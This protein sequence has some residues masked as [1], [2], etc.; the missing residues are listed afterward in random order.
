MVMFPYSCYSKTGSILY[1][2]VVGAIGHDGMFY[3]VVQTLTRR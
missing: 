1:I 2:S 3:N